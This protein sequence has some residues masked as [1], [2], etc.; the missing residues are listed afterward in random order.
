MIVHIALFKWKKGTNKISI[1]NALADVRKLKKK[2]DGLVDIKCGE[3]F[4]KWN[5]G[6]TH[7]IIVLA[8]DHTSLDAYRKHTFHKKVAKKIESMEEKS[9]GIDFED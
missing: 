5:E 3:N 8:K 7:A 4:S 1:K 2:I 6:F 9:I